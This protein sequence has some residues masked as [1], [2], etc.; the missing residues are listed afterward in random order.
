MVPAGKSHGIY[1]GVTGRDA[2]SAGHSVALAA[3][4]PRPGGAV[5]KHAGTWHRGGTN[6]AKRGREDPPPARVQTHPLLHVGTLLD[7]R[8]LVPVDVLFPVFPDLAPCL[9]SEEADEAEENDDEEPAGDG[10]SLEGWSGG[11]LRVGCPTG[12]QRPWSQPSWGLGAPQKWELLPSSQMLLMFHPPSR[13]GERSRVSPCPGSWAGAKSSRAFGVQAT[14]RGL[15]SPWRQDGFPRA[16]SL[17]LHRNQGRTRP[18][19]VFA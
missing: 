16:R 2:A 3:I 18:R 13:H 9:V 17:R 6:L 7:H 14:G 4:T 12:M 19:S 10:H 11:V 1:N 15:I 5:S 8:H